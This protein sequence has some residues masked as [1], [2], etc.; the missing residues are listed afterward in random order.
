MWMMNTGNGWA[1]NTTDGLYGILA[2]L[3]RDGIPTKMKS[4][5]QIESA[6]DL[7]G[8]TILI[9]SF[10]SN[11]PLSEKINVAIADWV[12]AG[13]TLLFLSGAN[14][15]WNVED[16]FFWKEDGSISSGVLS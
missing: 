4:M 12:K 10:D 5:D 7:E 16:Y 11:V 15:Y 2:S 9:V 1:F 14:E 8:V 6:E 13:G 3:V